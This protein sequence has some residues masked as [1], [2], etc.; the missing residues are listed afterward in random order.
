ML[1]AGSASE[2]RSLTVADTASGASALAI[3]THGGLRDVTVSA[4]AKT[5][6]TAVLA[7]APAMPLIDV[8]ASATTTDVASVALAVD[9]RDGPARLDGGS[10]TATDG[11][12]SGEAIALLAE[13]GASLN[14][15]TVT[16]SG[17]TAAFPVDLVGGGVVVSAQDSAFAGTGGFA[18]AA[19]D[20]LDVGGSEVPGS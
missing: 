16:A 15:V 20:T 11:E 19:G 13:A 8:S 6:A 14:D 3:D 2:V 1:T 17:G 7:D 4:T 12:G 5:A 18:V 9:V 10:Y